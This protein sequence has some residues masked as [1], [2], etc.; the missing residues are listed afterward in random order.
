MKRLT[1]SQKRLIAILIVAAVL[2]IARWVAAPV[3]DAEGILQVH[4][5]DVGQADCILLS[6]NGENMLIDAGN[7]GDADVIL[8]Y[9]AKQNVTKLKYAVGTHPHEDH[10]G[11]MDK[12]L[13]NVEVEN[14][15][16][17]KVQAN[18]K[19]FEDVLDA[20]IEKGLTVTVPKNGDRYLLGTAAIT[21]VSALEP[22]AKDLNNASIML[23]VDF[24]ETSF[25]FT[26]DAEEEAEEA[27]LRSGADLSCDVL[28][29]GHHGS[30]TSSSKEFL[31]AAKPR[32][33]VISCGEGND[34][35]H[36]HKETLDALRSANVEVF[37]TDLSGSIIATC[38]GADIQWT[39]VKAEGA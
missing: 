34:Y 30:R 29:V 37:R 31:T 18:T 12:V 10:I 6:Q 27:A 1:R 5:I 36:P 14:L 9:L 19:T 11:S 8:D 38:D 33:A 21:A 7:N 4:F 39:C 2:A 13:L 28:K 25:L 24:G 22:S 35:G 32:Y 16:M 3:P 17:P 26:G 20:A 15:L 23:R